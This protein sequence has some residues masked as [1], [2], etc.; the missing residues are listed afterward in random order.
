M[1]D[2]FNI[3]VPQDVMNH[4]GIR[5]VSHDLLSSY[6]KINV[7][8]V[9]TSCSWYNTWSQDDYVKEN[10]K[11]SFEFF[12][13]NT[14]ESLFNK[15]L[16]TYEQYPPQCHAGPLIAYLLLSK[17]LQT[18]ES[19]IEVMITKISKIKI[20]DIKGEDVDSVVSMVR[21]TFDILDGASDGARRYVPDDFPK[22]ILQVL[23]TSSHP[24]FNKAFSEEQARVQR[25]ANRTGLRPIWPQVETLLLHAERIYQR[26]AM[27]NKWNTSPSQKRQAL[28]VN[29][30]A[31]VPASTETK[32]KRQVN[33]SKRTCWNC[34]EM[35]C[36]V[37]I[38]KKPRDE[39]KIAAN[40]K[41]FL[42]A[43]RAKGKPKTRTRPDDHP[44]KLNKNGIYVVDT[45]KMCELE[46][47]GL[48]TAL[49]DLKVMG[50]NLVNSTSTTLTVPSTP[51]QTAAGPTN[52]ANNSTEQ[53]Y[54]AH[55]DRIQSYFTRL[56]R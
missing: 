30:T 46:A 2:V 18:T 21:S 3:V 28:T 8:V 1:Y 48:T 51:N 36:S 37:E 33:L 22:T 5:P 50:H 34:E 7:D 14:K 29:P 31:T 25:E 10:M 56:Y 41:K 17:I 39:K 43:K 52:A 35:G 38:C 55:M 44:Q 47:Q 26:L 13:A 11:H 23:Q 40:R 9:S 16:E 53:V 45:K 24:E 32:E 15:M 27:E 54:N 4:H 12:R 42:A 19:A 20:R 6:M 49:N